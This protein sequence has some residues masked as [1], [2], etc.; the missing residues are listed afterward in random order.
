VRCGE[1]NTVP[2]PHAV[3]A[4]LIAAPAS[5]SIMLALGRALI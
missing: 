5:S 1:L 2:L 3:A 4:T